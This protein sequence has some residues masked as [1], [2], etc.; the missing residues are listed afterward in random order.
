MESLIEKFDELGKY[1]DSVYSSAKDEEKES[2]KK[3]LETKISKLNNYIISLGSTDIILKFG[4]FKGQSLKEVPAW[5]LLWCYEQDWFKEHN[6][7][8]CSY[9]KSNLKRLKKQKELESSERSESDL[10]LPSKFT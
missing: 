6:K 1:I 10:S 8:I 4:K 3:L 7:E 2:I 9:I 5:Y